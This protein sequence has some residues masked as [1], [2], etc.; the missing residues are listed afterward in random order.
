MLMFDK[1]TNRHRYFLTQLKH[2]LK[3]FSVVENKGKVR[4]CGAFNFTISGALDLLHLK[5]RMLWIKCVKSTFMRLITK[6]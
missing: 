2:F 3:F 5:V 4:K 6:W 1:Q